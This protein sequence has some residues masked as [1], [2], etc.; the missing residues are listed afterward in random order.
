GLRISLEKS[1]LYMAGIQNDV[2]ADILQQFPFEYGTLPVRYLGLPL[3]TRRMT[4]SDYLPLMEKIRSNI[5]SWTARTLSFAGRLQLLKS[6]V[7]SITNF[8]I[9]AF[10]LPKACIQEIDKMCSAFLWSGPSLN[11]RKAKVSWSEVCAPKKEGGLGLRSLEEANKV[12]MLKLI[13]RILSAKGS[14]LWVDWVNRYLVRNG[15]FWAVKENSMCGSWIWRK[16]LKYRGLA[17]QFHR[18]EVKNGENTSFWHD[19]WSDLGCLK[20]KLGERG[21]IDL[22]IPLS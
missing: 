5:S 8:W 18:V 11:N 3:L 19:I 12:S 17:K 14:S 9:A 15:S 1:T 6:V 10:R 16:L 21:C 4:S 7:F 20:E 2:K 22:G 13:W